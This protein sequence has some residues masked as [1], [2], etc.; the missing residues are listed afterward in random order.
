[1]IFQTRS[2]TRYCCVNIS[3]RCIHIA[4]EILPRTDTNQTAL[5]CNFCPDETL[6][7]QRKTVFAAFV[8]R[9]FPQLADITYMILQQ[10][11]YEKSIILFTY[12]A[13]HKYSHWNFI[14]TNIIICNGYYPYIP[15]FLLAGII[16]AQNYMKF[17]VMM[18]GS[19][20]MY[21]M[22][23]SIIFS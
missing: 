3:S 14:F 17:Y 7:K 22:Q 13:K 10:Y 15:K 1:M 8:L 23:G 19:I 20:G 4:V 6:D 2:S 5:N 11:A 12:C 18:Q 16:T 21:E 9:F